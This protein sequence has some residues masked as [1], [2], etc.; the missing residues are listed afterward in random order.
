[1]RFQT[2]LAAVTLLVTGAPHLIGQSNRQA[3]TAVL[4]TRELEAGVT[5][6]RH[7]ADAFTRAPQWSLTATPIATAGGAAGG[8]EFD[9]TNVRNVELLSDG[10]MATLAPIGNRLLLFA[11]NGRGERT[12]ARE[13]KGPGEIMAPGGM[14]RGAGDT[15]IV[16]DPGNNRVNWVVAGRGIVASKPLPKINKGTFVRP[17]GVMRSGQVVMSTAGLV[18]SGVA[19]RVTRPTASILLLSP[20]GDAA[21][22]IAEIPDLEVLR[23][24]TRYGGTAGSETMVLYMSRWAMA[25]AWDTVIATGS[26][27]GYRIDLRNPNGDMISSIRVATPRRMIPKATRDLMIANV[28]RQF[29]VNTGEAMVDP[30]ESRRLAMATPFADAMPPYGGWFV[31]PDRTLWIVDPVVPGA[32]TGSATAFRQDGAIVGRLAWN[33][34]GTPMAF[35]TDRVVMRE[36]DADGT[37][38]LRVY[39]INR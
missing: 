37:T 15:L 13:G 31:S 6:F 16:P 10:R 5:V 36:S 27:D 32:T 2:L 4:P 29:E 1:M 24:P 11:A 38:A 33:G 9:L 3:G 19:D 39:R 28:L 35:G 26:G 12:L 34:T 7:N 14:T 25:A 17:V 23:L 30:A 21:K 18:Q 22:V 20:R 8:A